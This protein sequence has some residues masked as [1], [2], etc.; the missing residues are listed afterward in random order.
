MNLSDLRKE[1]TRA[2]ISK[3]NLAPNPFKQFEIWF[4]QAVDGDLL[5]P[6]AMT[7]STVGPDNIPSARV[8][9]LK[10]FDNNGFV[11]FTNYSSKK[12]KD[13]AQNPNVALHFYWPAFERQ[14]RI[15][16]IAKKI[17]AKES[18][19]YYKTRPRGSQLGAWISEQSSVISSRKL[20][21]MQ[22]GKIMEKFA[23][24]QIPLPD[25]WGGYRIKP[26]SFEFW[27]GRENRLHDRISYNL[28]GDNNNWQKNRLAP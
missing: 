3:K 10:V 28:I 2:G 6:N 27:Q 23:K 20:L 25:F 21:E 1:Y 12:A 17:T 19:D 18:F 9:L 7:L 11:F 22:F 26:S 4:Q 13:I 16:G 14:L 24:G 8:V 5:E 15:N